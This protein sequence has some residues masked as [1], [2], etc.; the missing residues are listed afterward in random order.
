MS[1]SFDWFHGHSWAKGV[2]ESGDGKDQESTSE[3]AYF[4]YG[5]KLWGIATGNSVLKSR[6]DLMLAIQ[7]RSFHNY[8]LMESTN[9]NQPAAFIGNKVTG[10]VRLP[11]LSAHHCRIR[12]PR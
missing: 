6:A 8:F 7:K 9:T 10:I 1:R 5:L 4:S 3:D 11:S 12:S 2:Y